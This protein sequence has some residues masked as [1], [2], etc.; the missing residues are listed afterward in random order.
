M[1]NTI[2]AN[3]SMTIDGAVYTVKKNNRIKWAEFWTLLRN[4]KPF[5][6][7]EHTEKDGWSGSFFTTDLG[8][9]ALWGRSPKVSLERRVHIMHDAHVETLKRLIVI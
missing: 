4:G 2:P 3:F 8:R 9:G 5:A 6:T 1:T 7:I